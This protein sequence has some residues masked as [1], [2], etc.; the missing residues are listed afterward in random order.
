LDIA[1]DDPAGRKGRVPMRA[2]IE[3]RDTLSERVTKCNQR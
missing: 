2:A 1:F 3:Q